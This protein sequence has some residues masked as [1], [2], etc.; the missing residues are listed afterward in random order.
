MFSSLGIPSR[1]K[2]LSSGKVE[3]VCASSKLSLEPVLGKPFFEKEL[4]CPTE[5]VIRSETEMYRSPNPPMVDCPCLCV[6]NSLMPTKP[7]CFSKSTG[8]VC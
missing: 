3:Y 5:T 4:V 8:N 6:R 2:S 1:K 7:S